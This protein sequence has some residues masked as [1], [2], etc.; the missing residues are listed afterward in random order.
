[1]FIGK[2]RQKKYVVIHTNDG[3]KNYLSKFN[4]SYKKDQSGTVSM[5]P[6]Y[7]KEILKQSKAEK[8]HDIYLIN[9]DGDGIDMEVHNR[10]AN[11]NELKTKIKVVKEASFAQTY[12]LGTLADVYIGNPVSQ[13]TLW[14][15][16]FRMALG[17]GK[18]T[19]VLMENFMGKGKWESMLSDKNY[20]DLYDKTKMGGPW[21]A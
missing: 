9:G 12:Y 17:L 19:F 13:A 11:D 18:N 21:M 20:L 5:T 4:G 15:A 3:S 6:E 2:D 10:F 16:R 1:M 14:V 8:D 7:I